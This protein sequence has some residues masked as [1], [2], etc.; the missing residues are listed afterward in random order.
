M[1]P[2]PLPPL[3]PLLPPHAATASQTTRDKMTACVRV[4]DTS[5]TVRRWASRIRDTKNAQRS[6]RA[7]RPLRLLVGFVFFVVLVF[8]SVRPL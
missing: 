1:L 5:G 3:P 7:P 8:T 6:L 2:P 4:I